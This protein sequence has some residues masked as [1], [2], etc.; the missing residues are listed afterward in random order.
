[1]KNVMNI[2]ILLMILVLLLA[3]S[4]IV[5]ASSQQATQKV[6]QDKTP[7]GVPTQLKLKSNTS[8]TISITWKAS[9]DNIK[10]VGYHIFRN[11]VKVKKSHNTTSFTDR[12]LAA[13]KRY[14][15]SVLAVDEAGNASKTSSRLSVRTLAVKDTTPP[16]APQNI[17]LKTASVHSLTLTWSPS[18]DDSKS[19]KYQVYRNGRLIA[20]NLTATSFTDKDLS[21]SSLYQYRVRAVDAAGNRSTSIEMLNATTLAK[22]QIDTRYGVFYEIFVR[23]FADSN[24]DGIGD[25]KGITQ[26]LDYLNDGNPET[27]TDLGIDGIWLM[28]IFPSPSYHGYDVT[29][30]YNVNSQYGTMSEFQ[31]LVDEAHKRGIKIVID[32]ILNHSSSRHPWFTQASTNRNSPYRNWYTWATASTNTSERS[33]VGGTA[34]HNSST[35]YYFGAFGRGMPDLNYD[36][37][38]VRAEAAKIGR[39][40]L[41]LGVDG[42]RMDAAKHVYDDFESSKLNPATAAKNKEMWQQFRRDIQSANPNAYMVGE[43]WDTTDVIAPF[44]DQS[45]NSMF[46]FDLADDIMQAVNTGVTFDIARTIQIMYA[47]YKQASAGSFVDATFLS[48]HDQNRVMSTLQGDVNKAKLAASM[49]LT[50]PGTPYLYYGEE[51]GMVG[52][53]PDNKIRLPYPWDSSGSGNGM[54]RWSSDP[55]FSPENNK[56]AWNTQINRSDSLLAFYREL[57]HLRKREIALHQGEIKPFEINNLFVESYMRYSRDEKVLVLHNLSEFDQ[58]IV[59]PKGPGISTFAN[60]IYQSNAEVTLVNGQVYL[61]AFSSVIIK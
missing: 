41:E 57:I 8:T 17:N 40:W 10:V 12:G 35:G 39:Y 42:F 13:D 25:F 9:N 29:D 4:W 20:Q 48:N 36:H 51:L 53:K 52:V 28:P 32:L 59:L 55:V 1:M 50:L 60:V 7:P 61:P 30:Y 37:P 49:L 45:F 16:T 23:A 38:E 46:N 15:Y 21:P 6:K 58:E 34:W 11:G 43:T 14:D 47:K 44:L 54:T 18:S 26:K 5:F 22:E 19:V 56:I 3:S 27:T 24:G 33:A 31:T 2:L